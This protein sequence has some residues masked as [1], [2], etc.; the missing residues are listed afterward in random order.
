MRVLTVIPV[1]LLRLI[2]ASFVLAVHELRTSRQVT[3]LSMNCRQAQLRCSPPSGPA[4]ARKWAWRFHG[5]G[6]F[7]TRQV[8]GP[9]IDA[10]SSGVSVGIGVCQLQEH[11]TGRSASPASSCRPTRRAASVRT[12]G[13]P[14]VATYLV[15]AGVRLRSSILRVRLS[16]FEPVTR[17]IGISTCADPHATQRRVLARVDRGRLTH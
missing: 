17:G 9:G 12:L 13:S 7:G 6:T 8:V 5:A 2:V 1:A 3:S 15:A 4:G 10:R 14:I 16:R 11:R